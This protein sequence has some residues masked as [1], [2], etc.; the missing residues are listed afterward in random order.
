MLQIYDNVCSPEVSCKKAARQGNF[1]FI[2]TAWANSILICC[3]D[4]HFQ[5]SKLVT[6]LAE[7]RE[8]FYSK[9]SL[10]V[11]LQEFKTIKDG[12]NKISQQQKEKRLLKITE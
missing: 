12:T 4:R 8:Y 1:A 2:W 3:N 6:P 9:S 7:S 10:S 5:F 11:Y